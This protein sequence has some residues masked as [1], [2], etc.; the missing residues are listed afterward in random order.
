LSSGDYWYDIQVR[1]DAGK[2]YTIQKG[3]F[4]VAYDVTT[5]KWPDFV[6]LS[7]SRSPSASPSVSPSI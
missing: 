4:A 3:K 1:T 6:A 2:I 7:P 5:R